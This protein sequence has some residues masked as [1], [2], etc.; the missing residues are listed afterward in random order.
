MTEALVPEDI[1]HKADDGKSIKLNIENDLTTSDRLLARTDSF[2]V[3][4]FRAKPTDEAFFGSTELASYYFVFPR[5]FSEI[6]L[7]RGLREIIGP[8]DISTYNPG[9]SYRRL[10]V[11]PEGDNSDYIA[12]LPSELET[13]HFQI[14]G[15]EPTGK[16]LFSGL[17]LAQSQAVFLK[18]RKFFEFL[19][20][21]NNCPKHSRLPVDKLQLEESCFLLISE[22][23]ADASGNN[24]PPGKLDEAQHRTL[25]DD[26]KRLLEK[27]FDEKLSIQQLSRQLNVSAGHLARVFKSQTGH[28]IHQYVTTL[29]LRASIDLLMSHRGD[30]SAVSSQLGFSHHSHFTMAFR[31]SFGMTP[32]DITQELL[33]KP[34]AKY[35]PMP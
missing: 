20:R 1:D 10:Q 7:D 5:T 27:P 11:S 24:S 4:L 8:A 23:L 29:R 12:V 25:C 32:S 22:I 18:Q 15:K 19:S 21:N 2:A 34:R 33:N 31:K 9:D 16:P 13:L 14:T 3:G 30:I 28:S 6:R 17:K 35:L 26:L